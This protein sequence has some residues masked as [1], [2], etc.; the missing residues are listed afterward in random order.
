[1]TANN[2][3]PFY[4]SQHTAPRNRFVQQLQQQ[5]TPN[6]ETTVKY[7]PPLQL[8]QLYQQEPPQTH[9]RQ[10][11]QQQQQQRQLQQKQQ[12]QRQP[13][14]QP[15]SQTQ[16]QPQSQTQRQQQIPINIPTAKQVLL[17]QK[18]QEKQQ[19]FDNL[20]ILKKTSQNLSNYFDQL[21]NNIE[22]LSNGCEAVATV[23]RNWQTVFRSVLL[24]ETQMKGKGSGVTEQTISNTTNNN[25]DFNSD[26]S[27][28]I[29]VP[30]PQMP[31]VVRIPMKDAG[32]DEDNL[33]LSRISEATAQR[34]V[35]RATLKEAKKNGPKDY[36][37][38]LKTIDD[39]LPYLFGIIDCLEGGQLKLKK[40]I[41]TSWSCTLSD[42]V[43]KKKPRVLCKGIY[44]E[45]I[46][47]LLTYGYAYADWA[48]SII[49]RQGQNDKNDLRLRQAADLLRKAGGIFAYIGE[50]VCPKWDSESVSKPYDVVMEIPTS[51][52][53]IALADANSIAI[54]KALMQQ[55]SS[56]LLAKLAFGVSG[57]YEM[58][59]GLIKSLKDPSKVCSDFRKYVSHG[60]LFH[61]AL[62][63][64]FLAQDAYVHQQCGKA[65][66]FITEA[67]DA[68]HLLTRSKLITI[69]LHA[70]QEYEEVK[71]LHTSYVN[72][73]NTV[74]YEE[75]PTKADLQALIPGGR[76]LQEFTKYEPPLPLF[77]PGNKKITKQ[78]FSRDILAG[79]YY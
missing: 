18:L 48:T 38:I 73:N 32:I 13:L 47:V 12:Q 20:L 6:T 63:K 9:Q 57:H 76:V 28:A 71:N 8:H 21:A 65:V 22:E 26:S 58:A 67:K 42:S 45:L 50:E 10:Q 75:V 79:Q 60:T 17:T 24:P 35:V 19:E 14:P 23:L 34:G 15:Q 33:Y 4:V 44:Y 56:S 74:A 64:K 3:N 37:K 59:N 52:S 68:F 72:Y 70:T 7:L 66:G 69:A 2:Q 39:Y 49:E 30:E 61:Q 51:M 25:N 41:E 16:P 53:K 78:P 29:N 5:A 31:V 62:G 46:F 1:M 11:Q 55:T 54:R 40:E 27:E 43:L 36:T 77:G